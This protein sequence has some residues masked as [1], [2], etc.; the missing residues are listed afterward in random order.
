MIAEYMDG[1]I[2]MFITKSISQFARNTLDCLQYIRQL[3]DKNTY[4]S[5]LKKRT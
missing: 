1:N 2:D 3:K 4:P 5:I